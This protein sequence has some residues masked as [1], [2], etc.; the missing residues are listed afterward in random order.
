MQISVVIPTFNKASLLEQTIEALRSQSLPETCAWEIVVV[1]DGS[2]D[3]TGAFLATLETGTKPGIRVVTPGQNVGRAKARNLGA[4]EARGRY[5]LFMDDDIVAPPGLVAAH[6]RLLDDYP[7]CGTIGY[8][9]TDPALI[10]APH[11]S[12]LDTR[13]A[14]RLAAGWAPGR[15]FVT[16]NASVPRDN[17]L[18]VGGFDEQFSA[19]GFED[20]ELAFRLEDET[21]LRFHVL[22]EPVPKH[23]HHHTAA[24]YFAKKRECGV[25]SLPHLARK[26]PARLRE[27]NLHLVINA[28][29]QARPGVLGRIIRAIAQGPGGRHLPDWMANWPRDASARPR[30]PALYYRLMNLTVL[31]LYRQ[32]V[33]RQ[34]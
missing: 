2:T 5:L 7:N 28:A 6:L 16:Q 11:F 18:A 31:C 15:Y 10:D 12:Y 1:N 30:W 8:A 27:M 4:R 23:V 20:M 25:R 33:I 21:N 17:F 19:Y 14:A 3:N 13:G 24:E 29:P 26:H 34:D 32:G 9:V 22:T